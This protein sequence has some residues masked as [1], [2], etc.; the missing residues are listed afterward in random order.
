MQ[1]KSE[2][3][4]KYEN[5]NKLSYTDFEKYLDQNYPDKQYDFY[6]TVYPAMIVKFFLFRKEPLM[7]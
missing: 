6:S 1:K 3:Y 4:E 7:Q 2:D 5:G